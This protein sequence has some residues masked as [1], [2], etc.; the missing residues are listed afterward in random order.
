MGTLPPIPLDSIQPAPPSAPISDDQFAGYGV[1][2]AA[3]APTPPIPLD[4]INDAFDAMPKPHPDAKQPVTSMAER[5]E[6]EHN[7]QQMAGAQYVVPDIKSHAPNYLGDVT[8]MDDAGK[9]YF[10]DDKGKLQPI[11]G[12][13]H[14]ML[15]DPDDGKYK[16]YQR[17][18]ETDEG[19]IRGRLLAL[20]RFV[21]EGFVGGTPGVTK[22]AA[23]AVEA[24][25]RQG[26]DLPKA[27]AHPGESSFLAKIPGVGGPISDAASQ[28]IADTEAATK[29]LA[30]VPTGEAVSP[31]L[32]GKTV[33]TGLT[34]YAAP[35]VDGQPGILQAKID[36]QYDKVR[37]LIDPDVTSEPQS[38]FKYASELQQKYGKADLGWPKNLSDDIL[39]PLTKPGG[40]DFDSLKLAR[41]RV[42]EMIQD[43]SVVPGGVSQSELKGLYG[44]LSDD[45]GD[46]VDKAGGP[47]AVKAFNRANTYNKAANARREALQGIL[48]VNNDE[49][50][51]GT[52]QR[53]AGSSNSADIKLLGQARKSLTPEEW[54]HVS[55]GVLNRLGKVSQKTGDI[56]DMGQFVKDYQNLSEAGKNMLFGS[57]GYSDLRKAI[58]DMSAIGAGAVPGLQK[59]ANAPGGL[60]HSTMGAFGVVEGLRQLGEMVWGEPIEKAAVQAGA[61]VGAGIAGRARAWWLSSPITAK[62]AAQWLQQY[63]VGVMTKNTALINNATQTL[64]K[65]MAGYQASPD[66]QMGKNLPQPTPTGNVAP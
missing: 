56:F 26:V 18:P 6:I 63:K 43:P 35:K 8:D 39:G 66:D 24:A 60:T 33:R 40:V 3:G 59:T 21:G 46:L 28:G 64:K 53:L 47:D 17:T 37:S 52:L 30:T 36:E 15:Q 4:R 38:A 12:A 31:Q 42:G 45:L 49:G 13:D 20:G 41:Q 48:D 27:V 5:M 1:R 2:G 54:D 57:P 14:V 22:A 23:P 25:L 55:A 16:I 51:Q 7:N 29:D 10:K 44:H 32:A 9:Y 19:P 58:D 50:I 34:N 65:E 61:V 11:E 62:Y